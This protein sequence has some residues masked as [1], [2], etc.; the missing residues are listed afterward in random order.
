MPVTNQSTFEPPASLAL[1]HPEAAALLR[2]SG[3]GE[4]AAGYEH[5]L[6]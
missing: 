5:T 2:G 6:R 1:N 3:A 4:P